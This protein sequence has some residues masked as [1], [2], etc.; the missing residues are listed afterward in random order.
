MLA[1]MP[2]SATVAGLQQSSQWWTHTAENYSS[3]CSVYT[4]GILEIRDFAGVARRHFLQTHTHGESYISARRST[5]NVVS[6]AS[7]QEGS[8]EATYRYVISELWRY[9]CA[10]DCCC[11]CCRRQGHRFFLTSWT[12]FVTRPTRGICLVSGCT[13]DTAEVRVDGRCLQCSR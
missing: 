5:I 11:I 9:D 13:V 12:D 3:K 7:V 6:A 8:K 1:G 10:L 4:D 2:W